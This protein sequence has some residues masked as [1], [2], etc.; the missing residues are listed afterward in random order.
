MQPS[1]TWPQ[2]HIFKDV[3]SNRTKSLSVNATKVMSILNT[4][5][6]S[7]MRK[8]GHPSLYYLGPK[9]SPAAV[10][11]QDCSH[12]CLPGIPDAWNE[13]LYALLSKR[14]TVF[15]NNTSS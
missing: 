12:W 11:R 8:D 4:T 1:S 7:S 6:M 2:Y 9:M 15:G 10:R 14:T 13:I 5:I 3:I